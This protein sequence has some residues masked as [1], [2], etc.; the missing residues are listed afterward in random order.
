MRDIL[1]LH[2]EAG[3]RWFC[4]RSGVLLRES[5]WG[6]WPELLTFL[7]GTHPDG[8]SDPRDTFVNN[9][10]SAMAA[11]LR[12]TRWRGDGTIL[13]LAV[14]LATCDDHTPAVGLAFAVVTRCDGV[15]YASPAP[16]PWL[17]GYEA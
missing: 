3:D 1:L 6:R 13:F 15:F 16:L 7:A 2:S 14:P 4:Y 9:R 12:E 11:L 10:R 5:A 17:R 8:A